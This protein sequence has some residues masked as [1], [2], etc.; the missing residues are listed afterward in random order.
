MAHEISN[1]LTFVQASLE[2]ASS[3]EEPS[4]LRGA[5]LRALDGTRRVS[6]I[7]KGLKVFSRLDEGSLSRVDADAVLESTIAMASN[8]I[9]RRA[10]LVTRFGKIPPVSANEGRLGQVFLNLI[11]NA[12]HAMPE[13]ASADNLLSVDTSATDDGMI[14]VRI[15][16]TGCGIPTGMQK[17]IFEPFFTTKPVGE[18]TGLGLSICHGIVVSCG[19]RI[20]V[21]SR[22]GKGTTFG[23]F[24]RPWKA[25]SASPGKPE[26]APRSLRPAQNR[27]I[28]IIDDEPVVSA[29]LGKALRKQGYRVAVANGGKSGLQ[30]LQ[31]EDFSAVICDRR[32]PRW[33]G[34]T[35]TGSR[36]GTTRF[37]ASDSCS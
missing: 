37:S 10:R 14:R 36:S 17:R 19:G 12:V 5:I 7:V 32:C 34:W 35:C 2:D 13:T 24:L 31:S 16:D 23:V 33:A 25:A 9:K 30:A 21:E 27:R 15:S 6:S 1:P 8:E 3:S 4:V 20:D 18:G 28:L 26:L 22:L 11:I 29:L